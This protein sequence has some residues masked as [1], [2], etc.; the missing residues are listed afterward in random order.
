MIWGSVKGATFVRKRCVQHDAV[1]TQSKV[2]LKIIAK[3]LDKSGEKRYNIACELCNG[4]SQGTEMYSRGRRGAP[5]KGVGRVTGA[6]VQIS[7]SPPTKRN[8]P[9]SGRFL[10]VRSDVEI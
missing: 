10:F 7:P 4:H 6:R 8:L 3:R 1:G 9:Q 5:A 2:F